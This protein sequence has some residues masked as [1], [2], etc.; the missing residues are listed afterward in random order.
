M[1]KAQAKKKTEELKK[2]LK[3]QQ[4]YYYSK[5]KPIIADEDYDGKFKELEQLENKYP[6]FIKPDSPT[7]TVGGAIAKGFKTI[8][9]KI[10]FYS[11][12]FVSDF[13]GLDQFNKRIQKGLNKS[14][15]EYVCE[16]K[17]DGLAVSLI[18]KKGDFI[19]GV[20]RGDRQRGEDVTTNLKTIENIPLKLSKPIDCEVRGE[21]YLSHDAL[22]KINI[23]REKKGENLF[24]NTRNAASG[25]VR[26]LDP[27][28][29]ASRPL[30]L[31]IYHG[32]LSTTKICAHYDVLQYLKKLGFNVNSNTKLCR[33][34]A[35]VKKYVQY[36]EEARKKLNYDT[37]GIVIKV[38]NLIDQDILAS[39]TKNFRWAIA[40]KY[41]PMQAITVLEK[42]NVQVGRTGAITPVAQ[43][44]PFHLAGVTIKRAT[45]HNED[46]IKRKGVKIH[47][48][49][50]VQRAGEVIPE[51]VKVV[52]EKRTGRE[53]DFH[54]PL[55]CPVC[56]EELYRPEGEAITR[57]IN[58]RC[59]AQV[60]ERIRH[61]C[62]RA[63]MD[64]EH[65]GP[66][67]VEQL[68]NE[69][70]VKDVADLYTLTKKDLQGL[71]RFADKSSQ[72]IID[73][74]RKSKDRP[75][76]RLLYALGIRMVG[77]TVAALIAQHYDSL[78]DLFNIKADKLTKIAG[79]GPKAAA[80]LEYFFSEKENQHL[81]ERLRKDGVRIKAA[82]AK[83]LKPL[84]GQT[85]VF[86]G[87][88]DKMTRP[89]A[90]ELIR[91]LGGHP[92]SSVSKETDYVVAGSEPGS[93]FDKAKKL[94]V[95]CI[96]EQ[97][98]NRLVSPI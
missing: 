63:A 48:H 49:V 33:N 27:R 14:H 32:F 25:S 40:Y 86:T 83:G 21:V 8:R 94:G 89:E 43:L 65:V 54:M 35:E 1:D 51:V 67:V 75:H 52:K 18:Y 22:E 96:T 31:F 60:K 55:K 95:K 85:F 50:V 15:I 24:A 81:I 58:A 79:I 19:R 7:Q 4:E 44:R 73:S 82:K 20:T 46:E 36:W 71:T 68:V 29:T 53:K 78:K 97:E 57:C 3:I 34:L 17:I 80:S 84:K 70:L 92:S 56:K 88:M 2:F 98:F 87:G 72:N 47:D 26:Q 42:I 23:V 59:P 62:T 66:A 90:E 30:G 10:P 12:G 5:E 45:L 77:R 38:N 61:F 91:K 41:P 13:E 9:H 69:K 11:L 6:E 64:I 16:L 93:K 39:T 76:D 37:D 28:I 74:I